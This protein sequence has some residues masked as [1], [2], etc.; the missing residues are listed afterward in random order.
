MKDCKARPTAASGGWL[1]TNKEDSG[2]GEEP[3]DA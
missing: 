1:H 3:H 2:P